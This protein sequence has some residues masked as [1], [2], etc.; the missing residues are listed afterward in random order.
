M[1]KWNGVELFVNGV[2]L[3]HAEAKVWL[4]YVFQ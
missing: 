1:E 3:E 2:V 4:I